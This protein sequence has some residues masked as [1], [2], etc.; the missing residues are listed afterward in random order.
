MEQYENKVDTKFNC[1]LNGEEGES[2]DRR[3]QPY[4]ADSGTLSL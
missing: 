2:N 3:C 4:S 1:W